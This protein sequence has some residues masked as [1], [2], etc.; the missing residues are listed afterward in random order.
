MPLLSVE[1]LEVAYGGI[2]AV[3]GVSL[4][5]GDG[6]LVAV[7]GANGAGKTTLLKAISGVVRPRNGRIIFRG[8][9]LLGLAPHQVTRLGIGH[10]PEGRQLLPL[11]SVM[12]NLRLGA[13]A[14]RDR[15]IRDDLE[16]VFAYFPILAERRRQPAGTLSG[17]EQQ[18]LAI[19]RALMSRPRLLLL[20]EP[21]LGLAPLLVRTI[22][23]VIEQIR[24]A[25]RAILL[26]EQNA[27]MA[28]NIAERAYVMETGRIVLTGTAAELAA[29]PAVAAA[30]LGARVG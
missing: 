22:F 14:R 27:R 10:V 23:M 5:V 1:N 16:Q 13:Y 6:E 28:L 17:G 15:F 4:H 3:R 7:L 18:M 12:D 20:D 19:G 11:L 9:S 26:V 2:W 30:Y 25:G 24:A 8:H 21:S 29:T